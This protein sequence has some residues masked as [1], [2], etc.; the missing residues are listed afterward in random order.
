MGKGGRRAGA[1]RP[2]GAQ[3]RATKDQNATLSVMAR[4][5]APEALAMLA[6]VMRYGASDTARVAASIALL[7]RAFGRP[8]KMQSE[9]EENPLERLI[10][11]IQTRGSK[12]PLAGQHEDN[13]HILAKPVQ[14]EEERVPHTG[15]QMCLNIASDRPAR[16]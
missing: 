8:Q 5:Y 12:A 6:E 11:D 3:N 10:K 14:Q 9:V 15:D 2:A 16:S 7:D 1:G 4:Q 13:S